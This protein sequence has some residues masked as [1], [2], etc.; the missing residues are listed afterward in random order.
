MTL[1]SA[2]VWKGVEVDALAKAFDV[3]PQ[4]IRKDLNDLCAMSLLQRIHS[5][6]IYPSTVSNIGYLSRRIMAS[7]AKQAIAKKA[8]SM[9]NDETSIILNIGTTTEQV[10]QALKRHN[11]L[12]VI[13]NKLDVANILADASGVNLTIAG[14]TLR[15]SD[16]G[17]IGA[18]AMDMFR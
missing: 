16:G 2:R 17:I 1:L 14:G 10:A 13:T 6:V 9:I 15:K 4:T 7:D 18:T 3:S 8:A 5:G 11:D 12:M